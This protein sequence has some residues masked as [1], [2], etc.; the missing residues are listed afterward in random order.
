MLERV[1]GFG[2]LELIFALAILMGVSPFV[3]N[4][5]S[6]RT[7]EIQDVNI[8]KQLDSLK[9]AAENYIS[10]NA[11]SWPADLSQDLYDQELLLVLRDYGVSASFRHFS[12]LIKKYHFQNRKITTETEGEQITSFLIIYLTD[13]VTPVHGTHF[14]E[15]LGNDAGYAEK[16]TV[17]GNK[18]A[19]Q[20]FIDGVDHAL[21]YRLFNIRPAKK[22]VTLL[23]RSSLLEDQNTMETDLYLGTGEQKYNVENVKTIKAESI[24][25]AERLQAN[26]LKVKEEDEEDA[27]FYATNGFFYNTLFLESLSDPA[28]SSFIYSLSVSQNLRL[29]EFTVPNLDAGTGSLTIQAADGYEAHVIV[30]DSLTAYNLNLKNP[31]TSFEP[32]SF[33]ADYLKV[34]HLTVEN[35]FIITTEMQIQNVSWMDSNKYLKGFSDSKLSAFT[36]LAVSDSCSVVERLENLYDDMNSAFLEI[37]H[38]CAT[39]N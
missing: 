4:Q 27:L 5:M 19:W 6:Q 15:Y 18:G 35:S 17:Y 13:N 20:T 8:A 26:F 7:Q 23:S 28:K 22:E 38:V 1:R 16:G 25:V 11:N 9:R 2:L 29:S 30:S 12:E 14:L 33:V 39:G 24:N 37:P 10:I 36:L 31:G 21:V 3:Y 32:R 34:D